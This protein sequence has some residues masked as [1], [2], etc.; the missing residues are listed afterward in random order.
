MTHAEIH[1]N[2]DL[3]YSSSDVFSS[4]ETQSIYRRLQL[5]N[6]MHQC[7]F[8]CFKYAD[9]NGLGEKVC[10][11]MFPFEIGVA[12]N[13]KVTFLQKRHRKNVRMHVRPT[14]EK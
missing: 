14:K 4:S 8:T 1:L 13:E 9:K 3:D 12:S 5:A 10:R 11:S 6:Q 2:P 7:C